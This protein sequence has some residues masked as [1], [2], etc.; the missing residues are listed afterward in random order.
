MSDDTKKAVSPDELSAAHAA[1]A[2]AEFA[3]ANIERY[4]QLHGSRGAAFRMQIAEGADPSALKITNEANAGIAK[5][6]NDSAELAAKTL[7]AFVDSRRK[8]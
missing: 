7:Q 6:V 5:L 2:T 4:L 3:R 8:K 1:M